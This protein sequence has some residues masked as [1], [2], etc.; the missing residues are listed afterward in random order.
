MG[1][2]RAL[3]RWFRGRKASFTSRD[4]LEG[5]AAWQ[6]FNAPS[7]RSRRLVEESAKSVPTDTKFTFVLRAS[8]AGLDATLESLVGQSYRNFE[9][10]LLE[11]KDSTA[12]LDRWV[13]R[14]D[15][16]R[17]V[18][19]PPNVSAAGAF[20][21]ALDNALG[22]FIIPVEEPG[23]LQ[24]LSLLLLADYVAKHPT[25]D[26]LYGDDALASGSG[27]LSDPRFKPDWS[28]ELLLSCFYTAP[29]QAFRASLIKELGGGRPEFEGAQLY[30]LTLRLA[31]RA[32]HVGHVPQI[33]F[34]RGKSSPQNNKEP[35]SRALEEAF[36]RRGVNCRVRQPL[37]VVECGD[38]IYV[39]EMADEGPAVTLLIATRNNWRV[40]DRLL[41]SLGA[42][43]Y[44]NYKIIIVDNVSDE[45]E[46][47][48]YLKSLPH[49][50][51]QIRNPGDAFNYA[52][53]NNQAAARADTEFVLFLN[54]DMS[55]IEPS[56]LSQMVGWARLRGV[57]AVGARLLFPDG[58]VQH[59]G[60]VLGLRKGL[61]AFRGLPGEDPGYL[62]LA[63]VTRDCA[64]VTAAAMLTPRAL[65]LELGG[66]DEEAFAVSYNDV[67]YCLGLGDAGYRIVYCGEAELYHHQGLTRGS[68][69][70]SEQERAALAELH[71]HRADAYY[72][73]HLGLD[74][75]CFAIKPSVVPPLPLSRKLK[76][77][78][79]TPRRS[80][81]PAEANALLEI[82]SIDTTLAG[83]ND[84]LDIDASD[85]VCA[86]GVD[87]FDAVDQ[88]W[89]HGVPSLWLIG[90]EDTEGE[91]YL[92]LGGRDAARAAD[93]FRYPYRVLFASDRA[94]RR[95]ARFDST[96]NFDLID[97]RPE[98][99]ARLAAAAAFSSIPRSL[100]A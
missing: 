35:A 28:P 56:W 78:V 50:V 71:G 27:A 89:R 98:A 75:Q 48:A 59:G 52:H 81:P 84:R 79:V 45:P 42:T 53:I 100:G 34:K 33:L 23:R 60:V 90:E 80:E 97:T 72:S 94:R 9:I 37:W 73:P 25:T 49:Q 46:T 36:A 41:Q 20:N 92:D 76:L 21:L 5:F 82:S 24:E 4:R 58:S 93:C 6:A 13:L 22:D 64:G 96:D 74:G 29:F 67:D 12:A 26:L 11:G 32:R 39:P 85:V 83:L 17:R 69:T 44:R 3:R 77:L 14:D 61:T 63:K 95:F 8:L 88:A 7:E 87:A 47:V 31:E 51:L 40:L 66:F 57:G 16:I 55:V 38:S 62:A 86:V 91:P 43:T 30:D 19:V 99:F 10:V 18:R 15:R 2:K 54:D 68:G 1:L 70:T 65:F